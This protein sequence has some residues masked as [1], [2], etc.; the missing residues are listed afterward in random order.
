[1]SASPPEPEANVPAK[2]PRRG[3]LAAVRWALAGAV[4]AGGFWA[5]AL[6]VFFSWAELATAHHDIKGHTLGAALL[7]GTPSVITGLVMGVYVGLF[8]GG[9]ERGTAAIA[10]G[11][12]GVLTGVIGGGL[13]APA[14]V[15]LGEWLHPV[16]ASSLA[17]ALAGVIAALIGYEWSRWTHP[18]AEP[19]DE[20]ESEAR[21]APPRV[22]WILHQEPRKLRDWPLFRVLPV[23]VVTA[24]MLVGA[25]VLAPSDAALALAAV[26]VLGLAVALVMQVQ[27]YR[28]RHL[29][30]RLRK[31]ERRFRGAPEEDA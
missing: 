28:L 25:A 7:L 14:V 13:S 4:C 5:L 6:L 9:D 19:T 24:F 17:W 1:M 22:E 27:E 18:P 2:R 29:E 8:R 15:A 20:D 10:L 21:A 26:G 16:V 11:M 12:I 30:A 31:L 23:L 3:R